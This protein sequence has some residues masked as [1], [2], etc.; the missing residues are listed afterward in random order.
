M[1]LICPPLTLRYI[2]ITYIYMYT[3]KPNQHY[4]PNQN[5]QAFS[6]L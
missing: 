6:S 5:N 2:P 1:Y 3:N 4:A